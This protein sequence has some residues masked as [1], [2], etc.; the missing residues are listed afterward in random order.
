MH[1]FRK[2]E[3][4]AVILG[5]SLVLAFMLAVSAACQKKAVPEPVAPA[6]APAAETWV[7]YTS[8][9]GAFEILAPVAFSCSA[10]KVPTDSGD[11]AYVSCLAQP[12]EQ[13]M[14]ILVHS[15]MPEALIAGQDAQKLLQGARDGLVKQYYGY[16]EKETPLTVGEYPGLETRMTGSFQGT[17]FYV[18]A[19]FYLVK[20]RLY[21]IYVVAQKGFEAASDYDKYFGSF[22]LK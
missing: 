9:D 2:S 17:N 14:Y 8:D 16:V 12:S 19:R 1:R 13:R 6:P 4:L 11:I 20:N 22:T 10:K 15:D 21:Q 18:W 3:S 7:T 5:M